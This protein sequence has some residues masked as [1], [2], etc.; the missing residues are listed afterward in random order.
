MRLMNTGILLS[1]GQLTSD[2]PHPTPHHVIAGL[3]GGKLRL[4]PVHLPD[5]TDH[6]LYVSVS[7]TSTGTKQ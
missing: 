5:L 3:C 4:T 2:N 6:I 1:A 7:L